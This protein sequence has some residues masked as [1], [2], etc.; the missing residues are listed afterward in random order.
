MCYLEN[1]F[2]YKAK[3][4]HHIRIVNCLTLSNE[5][6][7]VKANPHPA[8]N[9]LRIIALLVVGGALANPNGL[10]NFNPH[11]S[12][13]MST[14]SIGVKKF[15]RFGLVGIGIPCSDCNIKI[16]IGLFKKYCITAFPHL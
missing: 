6:V 5:N 16:Q 15:G 1:R 9:A 2:V 13:L 8:S 7:F 12:T 14:R 3:A 4:A 11:T 10:G